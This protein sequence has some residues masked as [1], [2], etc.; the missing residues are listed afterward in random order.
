[1]MTGLSSYDQ[2]IGDQLPPTHCSA[3]RGTDY[4]ERIKATE[5]NRPKVKAGVV[6]KVIT[7][8][9]AEDFKSI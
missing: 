1:M 2:L 6:M 7:S 4:D 8:E 3:G 5:N 9:R